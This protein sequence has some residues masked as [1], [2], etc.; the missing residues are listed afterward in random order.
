MTSVGGDVSEAV[1]CVAIGDEVTP[2]GVDTAVFRAGL[3][4]LSGT[5]SVVT[6]ATETLDAF[7]LAMRCP[8]FLNSKNM[9]VWFSK[10]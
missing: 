4:P 9:S 5:S 7:F 6:S 10:S 3:E 8:I 2:L 1:G